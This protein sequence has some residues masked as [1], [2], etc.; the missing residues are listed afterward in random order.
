M[1][2]CETVNEKQSIQRKTRL[3]NHIK[4][5]CFVHRTRLEWMRKDGI[6]AVRSERRLVAF[7]SVHELR[8]GEDPVEAGALHVQVPHF[9]VSVSH[10]TGLQF[11]IH[12]IN[13]CRHF[14]K[15]SNSFFVNFFFCNL[16]YKVTLIKILIKVI[17]KF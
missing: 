2:Q 6:F 7:N 9:L 14:F 4:L 17:D 11:V 3:N 8:G 13:S 1:F 5:G 12:K 10:Q 16:T 15:C